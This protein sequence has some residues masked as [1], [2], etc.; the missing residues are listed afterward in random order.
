VADI[1]AVEAFVER[2]QMEIK[3]WVEMAGNNAA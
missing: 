2:Y 1:L 3:G